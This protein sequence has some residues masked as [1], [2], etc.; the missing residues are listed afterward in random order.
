M[1]NDAGRP[2]SSPP[3]EGAPFADGPPRREGWS[4]AKPETLPRRRTVWPAA[5][6][7]GIVLTFFGVVTAWLVVIAGVA[8]LGVATAGWIGEVRYDLDGDR[9]DG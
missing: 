9:R 6:A 5:A 3:P 7:L 2:D 1:S 8:L 4:V